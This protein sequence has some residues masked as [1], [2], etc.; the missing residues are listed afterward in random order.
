MRDERRTGSEKSLFNKLENYLSKHMN[1]VGTI[2]RFILTL[3]L[4]SPKI[5]SGH[6]IKTMWK[7]FNPA[8]AVSSHA[9]MKVLKAKKVSD[10]C[11]DVG[12]GTGILALE[13]AMLGN[14]VIACDINVKAGEIT[15]INAKECNLYDNIDVVI[16]DGTEFLR[17]EA[18]NT[19]VMNP[20]YIPCYRKNHLDPVCCGNKCELLGI[21]LRD[22][23]RVLKPGGNLIFA[24]STFTPL[25]SVMPLECNIRL[26]AYVK[27]RIDTIYVAQLSKSKKSSMFN[28][29][30]GEPMKI[31]ARTE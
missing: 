9:L 6:K 5:S 27:T 28:T 8:L 12:T 16:G 3:P 18:V 20:P 17:S 22:A 11:V 25:S 7:I 10:I 4:P 30:Y 2:L 1:I 15:V 21:L 29:T 14:Y 13:M 19:I 26:L 31:I 24:F 23:L